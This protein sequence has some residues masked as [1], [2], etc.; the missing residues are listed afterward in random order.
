M[1]ADLST[2]LHAQ[3][4]WLQRLAHDLVRA[5][6]AEDVVQETLRVAVQHPPRHV[7]TVRSWLRHVAQN[8]ARR[9]HRQRR[10]QHVREQAFATLQANVAAPDPAMVLAHQE[11]VVTVARAVRDLEE[12]Y[13]SAVHLRYS[14][15]LLPQQIAER[16]GTPLA[17]VKTRLQRAREQLRTMLDRRGA[18]SEWQ[19]ALLAV[20][21]RETP[22]TTTTTPLV[23]AMSAK[24]KLALAVPFVLLAVLPFVWPETAPGMPAAPRPTAA[25]PAVGGTMVPAERTAAPL[26]AAPPGVTGRTAL[27]N[28]TAVAAVRG[29][30]LLGTAAAGARPIWTHSAPFTTAADGTFTITAE[31]GV[32]VRLVLTDARWQL[33]GPDPTTTAPVTAPV[34]LDLTLQPAPSEPPLVRG[35][36]VDAEGRPLTGA[37]VFAGTQLRARGD[38]PGKPFAKERIKDGVTTDELGRFGLATTGFVTAWH[39]EHSPR[40]VR[41]DDAARLA[42]L[43]LVRVRGRL[44]DAS[45]APRA[46]TELR[47]DRTNTTRTDADGRFTFTGVE[48]GAHLVHV[49]GANPTKLSPNGGGPWV[50]HGPADDEV[51]LTPGLPTLTLALGAPGDARTVALVG[52]APGTSLTFGTLEQGRVVLPNVVPGDYQLVTDC[53]ALRRITVTGAELRCALDEAPANSWFV[54]ATSEAVALHASPADADDLVRTLVA[55]VV[56]RKP[57]ADGTVRLGPLP[58][59]DYEVCRGDEPA[60]ERIVV[61]GPETHWSL[62]QHR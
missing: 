47:L 50:V 54:V 58:P 15:G 61:R 42:L 52:L 35:L 22:T 59:G 27:G 5:E 44:L 53:G 10:R 48:H 4:P 2:L 57:E 12:P 6:D 32:V 16:T 49:P 41:A 19:A 51:T 24:T 14:E 36:V 17:T 8:V 23:L 29:V 37:L 31:A 38:E 60:G 25:S 33:V 21:G 55:R 1:T 46:D 40:T 39:P 18:R 11:L 62:P 45:G 9:W 7:D 34:H 28:G 30:A 13:R 56:R 3:R 20:T 26:P 43:P